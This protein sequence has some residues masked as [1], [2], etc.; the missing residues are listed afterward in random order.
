MANLLP[1]VS[2]DGRIRLYR[3]ETVLVLPITANWKYY[4]SEKGFSLTD[5]GS[6]PAETAPVPIVVVD[7]AEPAGNPETNGAARKRRK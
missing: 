5:P 3:G 1:P 4:V 7:A 2:T 6:V